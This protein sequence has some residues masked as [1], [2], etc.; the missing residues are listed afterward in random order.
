M[1]VFLD[2]REKYYGLKAAGEKNAL[3]GYLDAKDETNIRKKLDGYKSWLAANKS[4]SLIGSVSV[5]TQGIFSTIGHF[6]NRLLSFLA[7]LSGR[8]RVLFG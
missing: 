7:S 6:F 5:W 3:H 4:G 2:Y 1:N 8:L